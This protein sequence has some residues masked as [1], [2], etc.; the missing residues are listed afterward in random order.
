M[1]KLSDSMTE[2]VILAWAKGEGE[3]VEA[4]DELAEIETDKATVALEAEAGGVL[5]RLAPEGEAIPVGAVIARIGE[6]AAPPPARKERSGPAASPLARRIAAELG[7]ELAGVRPSGPRGRILKADVWA[8]AERRP[9]E[10]RPAPPAKVVGAKG[11][12]RVEEVSR[13]QRIVAMRMSESRATV[14]EFAVSAE[15]EMDAALELRARLRETLDPPPSINDLVVRAAAVALGRH[16]RVNASFGAAGFE[17]HGGINV[18]LA[19]AAEDA[20]LVPVVADA[21]RRPLADLAAETR[22]LAAAARENRLSPRELD[23]ATFTISNLGMFGVR[24]FAGI[25]DTPCAAILCVGAVEDRALVRGGELVAGKAM[26]VTLVSDHRILY[27]SDAAAFLAEL[28]SLLQ[29]PFSL[30][31]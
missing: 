31:V 4:G 15:I 25:I 5:H 3:L 11:E 2:G 16:P 22:R 17:L 19:V 21:D 20:L 29:A 7:V 12:T 27:G 24:S 14:P 18:G 28:R 8:A 9:E 26:D 6:G 10:D 30:L 1:P 23:G 13:L